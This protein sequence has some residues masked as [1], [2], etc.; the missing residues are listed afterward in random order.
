[1][2]LT[3]SPEFQSY[4]QLLNKIEAQATHLADYLESIH[5]Q[6]GTLQAVTPNVVPKASLPPPLAKTTPTTTPIDVTDWIP[7]SEFALFD[8]FRPTFR[9]EPT[10]PWSLI[11]HVLGRPTRAR[12][13]DS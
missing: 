5:K 9:M 2:S 1:M 4:Q 3:A 6:G 11:D 7:L 10:A 12:L 13:N 8:L